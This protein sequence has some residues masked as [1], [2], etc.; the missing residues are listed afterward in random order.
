M[1]R[2]SFPSRNAPLLCFVAVAALYRVVLAWRYYGWEEDDYANL[3]R[4]VA[5]AYNGLECVPISHMPLYY[6]VN[7][8]LI[9]VFGHAELVC[10]ATSMISG[11]AALVFAMLI[12]RKL[13]GKRLEGLVGLI[14]LV[15]P[16]FALY[17]STSLRE[18][19][20]VALGLAGLWLLVNE[21]RVLAGL[22]MGGT[23]LVRPEAVLV[24][25]PV[26]VILGF[27]RHR[28]QLVGFSVGLGCLLATLALWTL[29]VHAA[30][31]SWL[32]VSPQLAPNL[33]TTGGTGIAH[34]T[35]ERGLWVGYY[36]VSW[37]LPSR[38]GWPLLVGAA[39]GVVLLARRWRDQ[40][41]L[42]V[43]LALALTLV[44]WLSMGLVFQHHPAHNLFWKWLVAPVPL[45]AIAGGVG[46]LAVVDGLARLRWD[47]AMRLGIHRWAGPALLALTLVWFGYNAVK[48]TRAQIERADELFLPQVELARYIERELPP[49]EVLILDE[50]PANYLSRQLHDYRI[51]DW[52]DVEPYAGTPERFEAVLLEQEV[53]YVLWFRAPWIRA[54]TAAPFLGGQGRVVLGQLMLDPLLREDQ[55]GWVWYRVEERGVQPSI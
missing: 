21:R 33:A 27:P 52:R 54:T 34:R 3:A 11:L 43:V 50:I 32:Y 26:Y 37:L 41:S 18:P 48:Q 44:F 2:D 39:L 12:A 29:W 14:L 6:L 9:R 8:G 7:A 49:D 30:T 40:A 22:A 28:R 20:Y 35:L 13:G 5:V 16:E 10:T 51:V 36:M 38:M 55:Y 53:E 19:M 31:G 24:F 15:Q 47:R 42:G 46:L 45:L 1:P 25:W 17:A 23:L 4:S